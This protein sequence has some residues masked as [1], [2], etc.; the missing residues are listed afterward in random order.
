MTEVN[1]IEKRLEIILGLC[2]EHIPIR[3]YRT[4]EDRLFDTC[5]YCHK[6]LLMDDTIYLIA[7]YYSGGELRE[8]IVFCRTCSSQLRQGYSSE[9]Q[10]MLKQLYNAEYVRKRL[11]MLVEASEN[12]DKVELMTSFCALCSIN[13]TEA[14]E[15]FEYALCK[16][17]EIM[18]YTH[19]SMICSKCTIQ[20]YDRLSTQTKDH[21]HR[22]F[23]EQFG[24]PPSDSWLKKPVK[25][26]LGF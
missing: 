15:Y 26:I 4:F 19:P 14:I 13:R 25:V 24:F 8:E 9:S 20:V 2:R 22:F 21:R 5:S 10:Q 3:F 1:E 12:D 16:G 17:D 18:F 23:E 7:K 11:K 6:P